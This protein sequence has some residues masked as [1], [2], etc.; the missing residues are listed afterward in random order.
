LANDLSEQLGEVR[1]VITQE[2]GFDDED[3]SRVVSFQ[4]ATE[5][6]G[7]SCNAQRGTFVRVLCDTI[8]IS[9]CP[10]IDC[11]PQLGRHQSYLEGEFLETNSKTR[12]WLV[13]CASS[14]DYRQ[15]RGWASGVLGCNLDAGDFGRLKRAV[16]VR[17]WR[18]EGAPANS[19]STM[20]LQASLSSS[21]E[22]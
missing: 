8:P 11:R 10:L 3:F 9:Y 15:S 12:R 19:H 1:Q 22:S 17:R 20:T 14:C 7:L 2:T 18:G 6:L 4:L 5:K 13:S 16:S 21:L